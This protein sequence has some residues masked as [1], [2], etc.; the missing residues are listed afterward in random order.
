MVIDD[1][2]CAGL[3]NHLFRGRD[4]PACGHV[5]FD[6]ESQAVGFGHRGDPVTHSIESG[7]SALVLVLT[8]V[9][10]VGMSAD[11]LDADS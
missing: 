9:L 6:R 1:R 10:S 8:K 4:V 2:P 11:N 7:L 5:C 3:L